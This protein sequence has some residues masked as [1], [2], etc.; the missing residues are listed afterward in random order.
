[1]ADPLYASDPPGVA[2]PGP[3]LRDRLLHALLPAPCL[4]CGRPLP[5]A[6]TLL[7]LCG[8]CRATLA[9]LPRQGCAV[10]SRPLAAH[11]PPEGY[12]CGACRLRPPAFDRLIAL[13]SYQPPLDAVV[14]AFKFRRLDYLGLHLAEAL[15]VELGAA[16]TGFDLLV[17]VPLHWRRRLARG[18][19]QAE[20][21]ARP[22]AGRL[23][24]PFAPVLRRVHATPPQS[25]LGR[26]DR[27]ANLR[28]AFRVRRNAAVH[29]L[30]ILLVDD[31]TTTGATLE[32]AASALRNAGAAAVT[33]LAAGRT[34]LEPERRSA[35]KDPGM[36]GL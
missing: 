30:R 27:L 25:L 12:L 8:P 3:R 17:P 29:S 21:I 18:Y 6:R 23:G 35:G 26:E 20:R 19:N 4:G 31:V 2:P 13:W 10:C 5:A 11:S 15:A 33:A 9:R 16:L 1:M 32:A 36:L 22:L 14:Q 24:I 34:P 7:G 28:R